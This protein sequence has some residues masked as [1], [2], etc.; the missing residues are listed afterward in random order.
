MGDY[1]DRGYHSVEVVTLL[2]CLK[3][4]YRN[5]VFML[6]G[7][8]ESRQITHVY[9]FYDECQRK[10]GN[11]NVWKYLTELFD[12]LPL[13]ATIDSK[14]LCLHGGLSPSI[15]SL[16]HI[17]S[18][19]RVQEI[20]L[21]GP[22]CDLMWS[23]PDERNGWGISPRGA[24]YTFGK[25]IS[26]QFIRINNLSIIYRAHQLVME[27][28]SSSHD[29]NVITIFSAPNYCYRCGNQAGF[30]E[31][32]DQLNSKYIQFLPAPRSDNST[33]AKKCTPSYFL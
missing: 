2:L 31:V 15:D 28:Y 10:Y 33:Q 22:M 14:I 26:D 27:G 17:R 5:R 3:L 29:G 8:H 1:V 9:G 18:L 24:G 11:E 12:Y 4:R 20:P 13:G 19:D 21:D 6:R 23:D 7:N 30:A 16:E 25:D 32:D